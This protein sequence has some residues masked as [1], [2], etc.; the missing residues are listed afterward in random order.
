MYI[1][2]F[3]QIDIACVTS[4]PGQ[5]VEYCQHQKGFLHASL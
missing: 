4:S 1:N 2:V 3:S 5:E